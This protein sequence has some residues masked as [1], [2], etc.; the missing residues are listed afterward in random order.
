MATEKPGRIYRAIVRSKSKSIANGALPLANHSLVDAKNKV[1][2]NQ[3]IYQHAYKA[4]T[5]IW[6]IVSFPHLEGECEQRGG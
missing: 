2:E 3:R 1:H 4:H 5:R 6:R